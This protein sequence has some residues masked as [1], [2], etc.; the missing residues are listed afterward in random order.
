MTILFWLG[1]LIAIGAALAFAVL[2]LLALYGGART[3][4]EQLIPGFRPDSPAPLTRALSLAA[5]WVP[6]GVVAFFGLYACV[7]ILA[8]ML[9]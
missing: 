5:V 2:G 3:T 9:G 8:L 1:L 6:V 4:R 7:H